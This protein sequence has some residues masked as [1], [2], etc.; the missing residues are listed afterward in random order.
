MQ[1]KTKFETSLKRLEEITQKL[2]SSDLDLDDALSLYEE[3][4]KLCRVC[5]T[6]LSEAEKKVKKLSKTLDGHFVLE[7]LE[8]PT[9]NEE[10]N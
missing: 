1:E 8:E 10:E 4:V 7:D 6:K 9:K 5:A 2:E 3:G